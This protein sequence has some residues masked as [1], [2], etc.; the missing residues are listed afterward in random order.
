[1]WS[2]AHVDGCGNAGRQNKGFATL[3]AA[4]ILAP[5]PMASINCGPF[6]TEHAQDAGATGK[7]C[8]MRPRRSVH[9]IG[10]VHLLFI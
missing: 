9:A 3:K 6:S 2:W 8:V 10:I 5:R 7:S 4:P 1:M